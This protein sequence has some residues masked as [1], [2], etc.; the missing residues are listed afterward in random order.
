MGIRIKNG[1]AQRLS[2]RLEKMAVASTRQL[3]RVHRDGAY[4]MQGVAQE[5]APFKKGALEG[6]I[7]VVESRDG[8]SRK[9][10]EIQTSGVRYAGYIHEGVYDLGPGSLAKQSGGR[11]KVG[12]K[13]LSRALDWL[14]R[15]W[16]IIGRSRRAVSRGLREGR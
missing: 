13:F 16:D 15:D 1:G 2:V 5:M 4:L 10:F 6:S 3:R 12:R 9:V 7:E 8:A 11:F 14:R